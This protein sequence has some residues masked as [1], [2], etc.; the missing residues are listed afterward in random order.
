MAEPLIPAV[1]TLPPGHVHRSLRSCPPCLKAAHAV[2]AKRW[3]LSWTPEEYEQRLAAS[4][5]R[6]RLAYARR[7]IATKTC[8]ICDSPVEKGHRLCP[9]CVKES[10]QWRQLQYFRE[11]RDEMN[12]K[13][14]ARAV[15]QGGWRTAAQKL[16]R[17]IYEQKKRAKIAKK[18]GDRSRSSGTP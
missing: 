18:R 14:K 13:R 5:S 15:A 2:Y 7:I 3:Y 12:A 9:R 16:K 1:F 4:R 8:P 17:R 11:H 10:Q 6:R